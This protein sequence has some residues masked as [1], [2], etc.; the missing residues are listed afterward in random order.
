VKII[1][2]YPDSIKPI[3]INHP[4]IEF[5]GY[6]QLVRGDIFRVK[7]RNGYEK[8]E[9][10]IPGKI[11]KI[12]IPLNDIDHSFLPGHRVMVQ[13]Q[14]SWFPLFD[15]NPQQFMNIYEAGRED[16]IKAA[17]RVY[18]SKDYPSRIIFGTTNP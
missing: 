13:I 4:V 15:R 18:H 3:Y 14:S 6:E 10:V 11:E 7:Y 5:A 9:P 17:I 16:F 2:V 1:D 12:T 8:P